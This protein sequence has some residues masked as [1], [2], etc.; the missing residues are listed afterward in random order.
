M[1]LFLFDLIFVALSDII[2]YILQLIGESVTELMPLMF[3]NLM[4]AQ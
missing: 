1:I 4:F 2:H 3:M